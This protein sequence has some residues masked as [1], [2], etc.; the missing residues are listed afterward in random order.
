MDFLPSHHLIN[1]FLAFAVLYVLIITGSMQ[2]A[3]E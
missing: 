1:D 3:V 2:A